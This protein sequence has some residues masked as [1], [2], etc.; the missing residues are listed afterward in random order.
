MEVASASKALFSSEMSRIA[1][2]SERRVRRM[3]MLGLGLVVAM[4][5]LMMSQLRFAFSGL[6]RI[7]D[8][9]ESSLFW[10]LALVR[11]RGPTEA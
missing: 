6:L 3:I 7:S 1:P 5:H 8:T 9:Y 10:C 2:I 4:V 11:V